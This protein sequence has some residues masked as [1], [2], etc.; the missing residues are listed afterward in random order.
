MSETDS[1]ESSAVV[2]NSS[3]ASSSVTAEASAS[4]NDAWSEWAFAA[5]TPPG[6][7]AI[8]QVNASD[9]S[10]DWFPS[11]PATG[12][13]AA[14]LSGGSDNDPLVGLPAS[15]F[16]RLAAGLDDTDTAHFAQPDPESHDAD[17]AWDALHHPIDHSMPLD[18]VDWHLSGLMT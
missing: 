9:D 2:A 15:G 17:V 12:V 6:D 11:T 13:M 3:A 7:A 4:T 10:G 14:A 1:A 18:H 8:D 16:A 5:D